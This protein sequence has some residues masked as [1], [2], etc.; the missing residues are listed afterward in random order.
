LPSFS[1]A[2]SGECRR[3][4][5]PRLFAQLALRDAVAHP[6]DAQEHPVSE[7]HVV[8][9]EPHLQRALQAASGVLDEMRDTVI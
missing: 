7:R 5:Q 6:Q 1:I 4:H 9:C 3:L 2:V 8:L